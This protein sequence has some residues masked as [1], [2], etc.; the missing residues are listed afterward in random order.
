MSSAWQRRERH[1]YAALYYPHTEVKSKALVKPAA[2][3]LTSLTLKHV[4]D[5]LERITLAR[6]RAALDDFQAAL[7]NSVLECGELIRAQIPIRKSIRQN[8]FAHPCAS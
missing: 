7:C 6:S 2:N 3:H 1:M 8:P 5:G 4:P